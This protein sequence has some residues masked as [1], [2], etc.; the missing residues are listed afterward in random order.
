M[1]VY[2]K[3]TE[4]EHVLERG[5]MYLGDNPK[6]WVDE[7]VYVLE[8]E[9]IVQKTLK[10]NKAFIKIFQEALDNAIDHTFRCNDLSYVKV[11]IQ[12]DHFVI[13]NDG[14]G[15]PIEKFQD[16]QFYIPEMIFGQM[17]TGSNYTDTRENIG[18][19][20]G[21]GI[22][23]TNIY[24]SKFVI[25]CVWNGK[26][27]IQTFSSNMNVKTKPTITG[28]KKKDYT[29]VTVYPDFEKFGMTSISNDLLNVLSTK[30][31]YATTTSNYRN[32]FLNGTKL[33]VKK[34]ADFVKFFSFSREIIINTDGWEILIATNDTQQ[35]FGCLSFVNTLEQSSSGKHIDIVLKGIF[36]TFKDLVKGKYDVKNNTIKENLFLFIKVSVIN[37]DF[38][39]QSKNILSSGE[40]PKLELPE[41]RLKKFF[42]NSG[43]L[44]NIIEYS[45]NLETKQTKKTDGVK[46]SR[47][48]LPGL[49][50]A[51]YAG[52]SKSKD[53]CLILTEGLS[54]KSFAI[55][56]LSVVGG[57]YY[58]VFPLKGKILNVKEATIKQLNENKE[59][60]CLKSILGLKAGQTFNSPDDLRS[61]RYGSVIFMTDQDKD[62]LHIQ[63]LLINFFQTF[64]PS[65]LKFEFLRCLQTPIVKVSTKTSSKKFYSIGDYLKWKEVAGSGK[66]NIK[67][68]KGLGS[69]SKAEAIEYFT[70]LKNGKYVQYSM[71]NQTTTNSAIDLAF[72]KELADDRK[73]WI[74]DKTG[75]QRSDTSVYGNVTF[76]NFFD[77]SFVEFSIEDVRRSIPSIADGLKPSQR[78]ILFAAFKK[79]LHNEI[80]VSQFAGYIA[81]VSAYHHGEMSLN[82]AIVGMAQDYV[83]SNNINLL[84]PIGQFGSRLELGKDHASTR[85]IFTKLSDLTTSIFLTHDQNIL[86]YGDDDGFPIEPDY[87]IPIIPM[88]LVNGAVG[89]GTGFST[90]V[91]MYNPVDIINTIEEFLD[92][93]VIP[94]CDL[95]PY[96]RKFKGSIVKSNENFTMTGLFNYT[97][98]TLTIT[99]LPVGVSTSSYINW[100]MELEKAGDLVISYTNKPSDTDVCITIKTKNTYT[101]KEDILK[102]FKLSKSINTTN[103]HLFDGNN[104]IKRY[105]TVND[106]VKEFIELRLTGYTKRKEYILSKNKETI[107]RLSNKLRFIKWVIES[108]VVLSKHSEKDLI[109]LLTKSKYDLVDNSFNYLTEISIKSFTLDNITKL[110]A[111]LLK[112]KEYTRVLTNTTIQQLW[113]TDITNLKKLL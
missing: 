58:G 75:T 10:I 70:D 86:R 12:P 96:F 92:T 8:Q 37:P 67:Y 88:I 36:K 91:P 78:K 63:G 101:T 76:E 20:N 44:E 24:S 104:Q 18:G 111:E 89:I 50:D 45:K 66:Y 6:N 21:L 61:L 46:K 19:M 39:S 74:K 1:V 56:G 103:I 4:I 9:T 62:G 2:K 100:L 41:D 77:N 13:Q 68:L 16:T 59:I 15:I 40:I 97:D 17:R 99:E 109:E 73:D 87:Y 98:N 3:L 72:K 32:I 95:F 49:D 79:N 85:Y 82:A 29:K 28:C 7:K 65:L 5:A 71:N 47:L 107:K 25:E 106:I 38:S 34:F 93:G 84:E 11:D 35:E 60:I 52:T 94:K 14:T 30:V 23:L 22:K 26:K 102:D 64:W 69:S 33:P 90:N 81:E 108:N 105:H 31:F 48:L 113:K 53:C 27:Y 83:G 51:E 112:I 42:K 110:E 80:K 55:S 43:I 57:K 54:A